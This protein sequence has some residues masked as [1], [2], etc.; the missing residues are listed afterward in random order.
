MTYELR[1]PNCFSVRTSGYGSADR[2]PTKGP[3]PAL[4]NL[5][6]W[7]LVKGLGWTTASITSTTATNTIT[8]TTNNNNKEKLQEGF[9]C[10]NNSCKEEEKVVLGLV[11]GIVIRGLV[12]C[13]CLS[14]LQSLPIA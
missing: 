4:R 2:G 1:E 13:L 3:L 8:T 6:Y 5:P 9:F 11:G 7:L 10:N 14:R 12:H